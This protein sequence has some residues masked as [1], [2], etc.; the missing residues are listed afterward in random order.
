MQTQ[1]CQFAS[2]KINSNIKRMMKTSVLWIYS[3]PLNIPGR[4]FAE[5][6]TAGTNF[7][8]DKFIVIA[9]L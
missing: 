1:V 3:E 6:N 2:F 8:K 4:Y 9:H 7:Y 5:I